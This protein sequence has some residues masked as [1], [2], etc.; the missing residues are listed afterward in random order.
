LDYFEEAQELD[1]PL[2]FSKFMEDDRT[3]PVFPDEKYAELQ[4]RLATETFYYTKTSIRWNAMLN[5]PYQYRNEM[6]DEVKKYVGS[7]SKE[8]PLRLALVSNR[9]KY[10]IVQETPNP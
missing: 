1:Q 6:E 8:I 2:F 4:K 7:L 3:I 10:V 9:N 5:I